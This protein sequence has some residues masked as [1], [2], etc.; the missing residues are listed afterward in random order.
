M[1][2]EKRRGFSISRLRHKKSS[3]PGPGKTV[4]RRGGVGQ[5][6]TRPPRCPQQSE[7]SW[8]SSLTSNA[9]WGSSSIRAS[10]KLRKNLPGKQRLQQGA[11][12]KENRGCWVLINSKEKVKHRSSWL[13]E[14]TEPF[15]T[16][17]VIPRYVFFSGSE[18]RMARRIGG[19][20]HLGAGNPEGRGLSGSRSASA[21]GR[22][23]E[24]FWFRGGWTVPWVPGLRRPKVVFLVGFPD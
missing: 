21:E 4:L 19:C 1:D 5:N 24:A 22:A 6:P 2:R 11:L 7:G 20:R 12:T 9:A 14:A 8:T 18:F 17:D 10:E 23:E 15:V 16:R 13:L 3:S